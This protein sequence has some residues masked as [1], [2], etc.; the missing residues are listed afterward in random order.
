MQLAAKFS[1]QSVLQCNPNNPRYLMFGSKVVPPLNACSNLF[2]NVDTSGNQIIIDYKN[3]LPIANQIPA[4]DVLAGRGLDPIRDMVAI[5]GLASQSVKDY[6]GTPLNRSTGASFTYRAETHAVIFQQLVGY[7]NGKLLP[8][9]TL[10][11]SLSSINLFASVFVGAC[12]AMFVRVTANS[13]GLAVGGCMALLLT[14]SWFQKSALL[15]PV[16]PSALGWFLGFSSAFAIISGVSRSQRRAIVQV[17]SSHLS[18]E[19]SAEIWRQI[20]NLLTGGKSKSRRLF[21][22][23]LLA[24]IEG[25]KRIGNSMDAESFT[26]W[27]SRILDKLGESARRRGEFVE[28]YTGDG[29]LVI[30]GA[31][32]PSGTRQQRQDDAPSALRCTREM[33]AAALELNRSTDGHQNY[34]LRTALNSGEALG[35]TLGIS[36]SMR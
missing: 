11:S 20:K 2:R 22:M 33:R 21:V 8:L 3:A 23:A 6:F 36:G 27:V 17:F 35:G 7:I 15:M 16:A 5:I 18:D 10:N 14:M 9:R 31:P 29:I 4:A 19:L 1:R 28:K 26:A 34:R 12:I 24:D 13:I 30:F 25:S 32:I